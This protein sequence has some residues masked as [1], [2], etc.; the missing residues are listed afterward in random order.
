MTAANFLSSA[1]R[2]T[3]SEK[4]KKENEGSIQQ[5]KKERET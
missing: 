3:Q 1:E 5:R 4:G 2:S